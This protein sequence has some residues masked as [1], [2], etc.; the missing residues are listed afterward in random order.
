MAYTADGYHK[1]VFIVRESGVKVTKGFDSYYKCEKFVNK[2]KRSK[3]L[4]LVACP[5]FEY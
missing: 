3:K 2:V 4:K 1:V 5:L